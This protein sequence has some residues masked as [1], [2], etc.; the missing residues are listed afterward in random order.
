MS[1]AFE[2]VVFD[3]DG[4]L[5]DSAPGI[6]KGFETAFA[7]CCVTPR[8]PWSTTLI[9]PPLLQTIAEQCGSQDP[10]LLESL[11]A[12]FVAYYDNEGFRLSTP[13]FGIHDLLETLQGRGVRQFIATNKRIGPTQRILSH[14]GWI[15]LFEGVFGVDSVAAAP[16]PKVEV[17]RHITR[18]F[19]LIGERSLYV[20]DRM[21]DYEAA[22]T[23]GLP[24]A[25][26]TWGF[27]EAEALVPPICARAHSTESLGRLV[28][29]YKSHSC[30]K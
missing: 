23:A 6:L 24:F 15:S 18:T 16:T 12:A 30:Q 20:G 21:E 29:G 10:E 13:Y 3:L 5:I 7:R 17:I 8:Q 26:A 9:G 4:T 28:C 1:L 2:A 25:L 22:S 19:D 27:S 14:L 11:R